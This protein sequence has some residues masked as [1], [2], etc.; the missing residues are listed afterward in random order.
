MGDKLHF[1]GE[2]LLCLTGFSQHLIY[3]YFGGVLDIFEIE[4]SER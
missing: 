3:K 2:P 1:S 4:N